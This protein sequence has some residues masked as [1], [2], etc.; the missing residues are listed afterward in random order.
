M[1]ERKV[2]YLTIED[3]LSG[4]KGVGECAPLPG[5]S[6]D[7]MDGIEQQL[8]LVCTALN[9][10]KTY[11]L[12]L[13][14]WPAVRFALEMALLDLR[15]G[16]TGLFFE[17]PYFRGESGIHTNGLIWM[18]ERAFMEKQIHEK[19][20]QGF[21][22]IKLK[23]GAIDWDTELEL[24][25]WLR[26]EFGNLEIR[27]DANGAFTPKTAPN[28]L[29]QLDDLGVHSI[30]QP[31]APGQWEEMALLCRRH[32]LPIALDEELIPLYT[33]EKR[34]EMLDIVVP[35][36]IILKPSLLGGF[37]ASQEWIE[38]ADDWRID[39][40]V[41]SALESNVGLNAIAQWTATLKNEMPQGLGTGG[42]FENNVPPFMTMKGQY[43]WR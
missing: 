30:E 11:G 38:L 31:I 43:L 39:W 15:N 4:V 17:S 32:L 14:S 21:Q 41:T 35:E 42:V 27:V 37:K 23:I 28:V 6:L 25:T 33:A 9:E 22:C 12:N 19:I 34:E 2:W 1:T 24:L 7:D 3:S 16:G 5:L 29:D 8:S 10:R 40:W 13:M 20:A 18:G 36:Y 26:S